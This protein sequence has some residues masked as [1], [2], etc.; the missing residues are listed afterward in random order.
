MYMF[1]LIVFFYFIY[2]YS[3]IGSMTCE[4]NILNI[5]YVVNTPRFKK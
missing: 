3:I 4:L 5:F 2:S 1:L